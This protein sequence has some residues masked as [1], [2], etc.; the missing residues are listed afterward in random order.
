MSSHLTDAGILQHVF[1][2]LP[3]NWLYLGAVCSEW[4]AVYACMEDQQVCSLSLY[5]N[6]VVVVYGPKTTLHSAAVASPAT[7]RLARDL[8][9][10][11]TTDSLQLMAGRHA[12]I[13]TLA[14]LRERG[15]PLSD[16]VVNT[17]AL[18]GRLNILKYLITEQQCPI[19]ELLS[20]YAARSGSISML[21]WLDEENLSERELVLTCTGAAAGGQLAALQHL[22]SRDYHWDEDYIA[23][24]AASSGSIDV[25]DWLRQQE[26]IVIDAEAMSFAAGAGHIAMCQYLR[27]IGCDWDS[28]ACG[29]AAGTGHLD[30]LRWLRDNGCPWNVSEVCTNAAASE[31]IDML[32]YVIEQGEVLDAELLT[33]ALNTAGSRNRLQAAQWLRQHGAQW[34][35]V[36]MCRARQWNDDMIVWARAEGCTSPVTL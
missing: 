6:K 33:R 5:G 9:L 31:F 10:R 34:P 7:A 3:G 26:G 2:F 12:D 20:H 21:N 28:S 4:K 14:V 18:S 8:G 30:V 17:V 15:M 23:C 36:L 13:Q 25:I 32:D 27:S 29:C 11:V 22:V 24:Y 16:T 1:T 19:P 35:A